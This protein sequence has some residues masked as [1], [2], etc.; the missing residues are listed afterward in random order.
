MEFQERVQ[1]SAP[2]SASAT[3]FPRTTN[4]P[5]GKSDAMQE[6]PQESQKSRQDFQQKLQKQIGEQFREF[7]FFSDKGRLVPGILRFQPI[8]GNVISE[9]IL[10]DTGDPRLRPVAGAIPRRTK[11]P[12][13]LEMVLAELFQTLYP[14][15]DPLV[16]RQR[17]QYWRR[18]SGTNEEKQK[19]ML[20]KD[21]IM[22]AIVL[23]ELIRN[24]V[25]AILRS[26]ADN[27]QNMEKLVKQLLLR[28]SLLDPV[29]T[30][31]IWRE[32]P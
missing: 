2:P 1:T 27:P 5:M 14:D 24:G 21:P 22:Q 28:H 15:F 16:V 25:N 30:E 20:T 29:K 12:S 11:T 18:A 9:L 23:D 17:Q 4:N 19:L 31:I 13:Q 8:T 26:G 32:K 7:G 3:E 10:Q 6:K